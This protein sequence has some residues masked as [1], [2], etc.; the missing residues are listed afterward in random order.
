M[1]RAEDLRDRS[2]YNEKNERKKKKEIWKC[3]VEIAVIVA[4]LRAE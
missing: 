3:I 2:V 4:A 1:G